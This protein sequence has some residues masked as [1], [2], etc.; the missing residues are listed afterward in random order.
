MNS[1]LFLDFIYRRKKASLKIVYF[2]LTLN[3][4][5]NDELHSFTSTLHRSR[6]ISRTD[7]MFYDNSQHNR[8]WKYYLLA[9]ASCRL[10]WNHSD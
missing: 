6:R 8:K 2:C 7:S 1:R 5:K 3:Q 4:T 10:E 9:I